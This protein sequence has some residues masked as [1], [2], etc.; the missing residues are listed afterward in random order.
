MHRDI[1]PANIIYNP[2]KRRATL[3]DFGF[4]TLLSDAS[5]TAQVGSPVY[6]DLD[7]VKILTQ[8]K[9][10]ELEPG[11]V[12]SLPKIDIWAFGASMYHIYRGQL[13]YDIPLKVNP[14]NYMLDNPIDVANIDCIAL[15]YLVRQCM[16][17]MTVRRSASE[18][19]KTFFS[20]FK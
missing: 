2:L 15:R 17:P 18:L 6:L 11:Y 14:Y 12:D 8:G 7:V 4:A 20:N 10:W 19:Y 9:R 3:V 13:P 1:K 16:V 5:Q